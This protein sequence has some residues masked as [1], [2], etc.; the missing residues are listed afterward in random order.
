MDINSKYDV[1]IS[2]NLKKQGSD[3]E[4]WNVSNV[5][6][7]L[8][9]GQLVTVQAAV[10]IP[11]VKNLIGLGIVQAAALG[12]DIEEVIANLEAEDSVKSK[13]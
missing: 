1:T 13:K 2:M 8:D 12:F 6:K 7:S 11:L 3:E 9:Y 4:G 10:L 5:Y